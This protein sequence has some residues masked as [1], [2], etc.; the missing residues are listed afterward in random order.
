VRCVLARLATTI[1]SAWS[2]GKLDAYRAIGIGDSLYLD[3]SVISAIARYSTDETPVLIPSEIVWSLGYKEI[4]DLRYHALIHS[5]FFGI[6][7]QV[8]PEVARVTAY[9]WV[10]V[11]DTH[12]QR[13]LTD[14]STWHLLPLVEDEDWSYVI[15]PSWHLVPIYLFC[16]GG[17]GGMV[18]SSGAFLDGALMCG[19]QTPQEFWL[20]G[21]REQRYAPGIYY[22]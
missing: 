10:Q 22:Y 19:E 5:G 14:E 13:E 7:E 12:D 3:A 16:V 17:A 18:Y 21:D 15:L 8:M 1:S 11:R 9:V 2:K 20:L 4:R 6:T